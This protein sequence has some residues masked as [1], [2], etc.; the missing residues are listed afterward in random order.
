MMIFYYVFYPIKGSL[1]N[2]SFVVAAFFLS[3]DGTFFLVFGL[4]LKLCGSL[5]SPDDNPLSL[6]GVSPGD[7]FVGVTSV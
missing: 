6:T 5:L 7:D 4:I 2:N 1:P 3:A